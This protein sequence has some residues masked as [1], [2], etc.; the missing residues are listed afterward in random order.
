MIPGRDLSGYM[1][2]GDKPANTAQKTLVK[3]ILYSPAEFVQLLSETA[4][5]VAKELLTA[6]TLNLA[7]ELHQVDIVRE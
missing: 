2:L 3:E 7:P 5:S 4:V 6:E 1:L